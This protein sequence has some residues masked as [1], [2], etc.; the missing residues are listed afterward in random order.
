MVSKGQDRMSM[1]PLGQVT[2]PPRPASCYC[3]AHGT[4][5]LPGT[6]TGETMPVRGARGRGWHPPAC[7]Q[8]PP[9]KD[10]GRKEI[11]EEGAVVTPWQL[12]PGSP[13][14]LSKE[15]PLS[16]ARSPRQTGKELFLY[17]QGPDWRAAG[18]L[19]LVMQ[20]E[21]RETAD[22]KGREMVCCGSFQRKAGKRPRPRAEGRGQRTE[23]NLIIIII[24]ITTE[25]MKS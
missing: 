6:D 16:P 18:E 1:G 10:A 22:S 15:L 23:N 2:V 17:M 13:S 5:L 7:Q 12:G 4:S 20:G 8:V 19:A 21:H 25:S 14:A 9:E 24:K 11:R 3:R